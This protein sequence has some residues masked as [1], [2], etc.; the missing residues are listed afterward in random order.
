MNLNYK[1][2][3]VGRCTCFYHLHLLWCFLFVVSDFGLCHTRLKKS[4]LTT[5]LQGCRLCRLHC[6]LH[7]GPA[8]L[9]KKKYHQLGLRSNFIGFVS[10]GVFLLK[11]YIIYAC[12]IWVRSDLNQ[13]RSGTDFKTQE[14]PYFA[15]F[16]PIYKHTYCPF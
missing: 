6:F 3:K 12:Q 8:E 15:L 14:G 1:Q 7:S 9:E 16:L 5:G 11:K 10:G 2:P 4:P 13:F